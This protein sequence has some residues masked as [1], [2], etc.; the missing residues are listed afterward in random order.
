V[1]GLDDVLAILLLVLLLLLDGLGAA[2]THHLLV[3]LIGLC[4]LGD[5]RHLGRHH[6]ALN[7]IGGRYGRTLAG[8]L[9]LEDALAHLLR[10]RQADVGAQHGLDLH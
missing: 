3:V 5:G 7:G 8:G 6:T 10:L 1:E 4:A 9:A 2:S